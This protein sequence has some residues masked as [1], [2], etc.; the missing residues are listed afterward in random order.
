[1]TGLLRVSAG[2]DWLNS[3]IG[4]TAYWLV[5]VAVLVSAGNALMR[6]TF[7]ISSNAWLEIQW[8][9]FSAVFLLCAAYTFLHNEHIRIDIVSS[10]M[11]P[12]GRDAMDVFGHLV[13]L[14]PLCIVMLYEA[15][16]YFMVAYRSGEV[17]SNAGGLLRWPV[18][19]LIPVGFTLLLLQMVSELI[20]RIAVMRG[21]IPDPYAGKGG[22]H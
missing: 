4:Q 8:Y 2:I 9:L 11:T 19:L 6:Y 15:W 14:M 1:M 22:S 5:L 17:S 10:R 16:P 20:K 12:R 18:R 13:F 7:N 21:L 3:R